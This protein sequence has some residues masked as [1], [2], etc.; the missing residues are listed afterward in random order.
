MSDDAIGAD[1]NGS[2][3]DLNEEVGDDVS[4]QVQRAT[5]GISVAARAASATAHAA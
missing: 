4:C 1:Q 3:A 5:I 2:G